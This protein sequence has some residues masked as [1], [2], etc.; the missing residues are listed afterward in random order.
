MVR[1]HT[2]EL[3]VLTCAIFNHVLHAFHWRHLMSVSALYQRV[4]DSGK[5]VHVVHLAFL[6]SQVICKV[7]HAVCLP[8]V[9]V[10]MLPYQM[11]GV[12]GS[13]LINVTDQLSGAHTL[14]LPGHSMPPISQWWYIHF[15]IDAISIS[16]DLF[17]AAIMDV[18]LHPSYT[19]P[20]T[21]CPFT[22]CLV[23]HFR[24][25]VFPLPFLQISLC[26][27]FLQT[28]I[29]HTRSSLL[30][31]STSNHMQ[32]FSPACTLFKLLCLITSA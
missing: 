16:A 23:S 21:H 2:L 31:R 6:P 18:Y 22:Q 29:P 14:P 3:S 7:E 19:S 4:H 5:W 9:R 8:V 10:H 13:L 30:G 27:I 20:N 1:H 24:F 12:C 32:Y 28:S 26:L 15:F 11:L 25:H 17:R